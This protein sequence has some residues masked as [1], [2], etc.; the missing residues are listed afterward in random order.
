MS[1]DGV[2][3]ST[4]SAAFPDQG[5]WLL[6]LARF[7]KCSDVSALFRKLDYKDPPQYF[8][9]YACFYSSVTLCKA[10]AVSMTQSHKRQLNELLDSERKRRGLNMI[11]AVAVPLALSKF[12]W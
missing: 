10:D 8:S 3:L 4:F 6:K 11:P 12:G 2:S 1:I 9:M 7:M 5:K